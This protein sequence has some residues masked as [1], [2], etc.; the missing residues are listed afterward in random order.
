MRKVTYLLFM[1]LL[2]AVSQAAIT[3]V[4]AIFAAGQGGTPNTVLAEG[5]V[6]VPTNTTD[7]ADGIWRYRTGFGIAPT[8]TIQPT[9]TITLSSASTVYEGTGNSNPSDNVPRVVTTANVPS[10]LYD[11]YV[12][13]WIDQSG[14]PWRIRAGLVNTPD[15][16]PEFIGSNTFTADS[17]PIAWVASDSG[18]PRRLMRAYL[19]QTGGSSISVFVEDY[20]ASNGNQRTWYDGIGYA[21]AY[22]FPNS[23]SVTPV[24]SNGTVGTLV[25]DT[26]AVATLGFNA[27]ADPNVPVN[28]AILKHYV[29]LSA[30]N[31]P[32]IPTSPTFTLDQVHNANP[33]LTDPFNSVGALTLS[34]ASTYYWQV[35]EGVHDPN[36]GVRPGNSKNY[37]GQVWTF[38]TISPDCTVSAVNPAL[39]AVDPGSS[40][41]LTVTGT[42]ITAYQWYKISSPS[43]IELVNNGKYSGATTA[44]LTITDI[45]MADE[46][47]YY[48]I[49]SNSASTASNR[50][51]GPG[52]VM[53]KRLVNHYPMEVLNGSATPDIVSG[54]DMTLYTNGAVLPAL[55]ADKAVGASSLNIDTAGEIAG[56]YGQLPAGVLDYTDLTMTAWVYWK[57]G[58]AFQRIF[59]FGNDVTHVAFLSPNIFGSSATF[60]ITD[61]TEQSVQTLNQL[62]PS[63]QW[64]HVA[65]SLNGNTGRLYINGLMA[66]RNTA[67][68]HDPINF[69]PSLNYIGK[70]LDAA[71]PY[72][73]GYIDD[74]KIYNYALTNTEVAHEYIAVRGGWVC[75]A[76]GIDSMAY[77]FN[78]DC[79]VDLSDFAR[80][81]ADWLNDNRIY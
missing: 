77:D 74:L 44:A 17:T 56:R 67:V 80:I 29:Y 50:T 14:S 49:V 31:D 30:P 58:T 28:P 65:V 42:S 23:P 7:S 75:D 20:P 26:E 34:A 39:T 70:S 15:P 55:I 45:Q 72:F 9:G 81:A 33:Q 38:T 78:R 60:G 54:A 37:L 8:V 32:N 22:N 11:V 76:E 10:G 19:G 66:S 5:G 46:G 4:D 63:N 13:F 59:A 62:L 71:N 16:L 53:I 64:V 68:T 47:L 2:A 36:G 27:G 51:A 52:R 35:E 3:Y 1:V 40:A 48:C 57:G 12:Y 6:P 79:R 21:Q 43:D 69:R 41:I 18:G 61:T 25:N 24:N 73:N